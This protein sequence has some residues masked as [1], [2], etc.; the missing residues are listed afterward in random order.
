ME[1]RDSYRMEEIYFQTLKEE[2][3][4]VKA[5]MAS[6]N[7]EQA[8]ILIENAVNVDGAVL[9][10]YRNLGEL[11][12][13]LGAKIEEV[14]KELEKLDSRVNDYHTELNEKIDDVNNTIIRL[15]NA[16]EERVQ[17]LEECC[18]EVQE[19]LANK[20][21]K[22]TAGDN[23]TIDENNVISATGGSNI[24]VVNA[25]HDEQT[26]NPRLDKTYEDIYA[27]YT[28]GDFVIIYYNDD[29]GYPQ[30]YDIYSFAN[31][32]FEFITYRTQY[33]VFTGDLY[34]PCI[35]VDNA[36]NTSYG[37]EQV[38][39]SPWTV[40]VTANYSSSTN[41]YTLNKTASEIINKLEETPPSAKTWFYGKTL[42]IAYSD[43]KV[44]VKEVM[45]KMT[46]TPLGSDFEYHFITSTKDF[47]AASG[48]D[49]PS[50]TMPT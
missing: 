41:K 9:L 21:D 15:I 1:F 4:R 46:Q 40:Y 14:K 43:G 26:S 13:E 27:A 31:D 34:N 32:R 39:Q 48:N 17:A 35:I 45:L 11:W 42:I 28:K 8:K 24:F 16:L 7:T 25:T 18:E 2:I 29:Y 33:D 23:I 19:A 5:L 22:L 3:N 12:G 36:N 30:V 44:F 6:G 47:Y 49:Y 20:Q 50:Y 37:N 38:L 10:L